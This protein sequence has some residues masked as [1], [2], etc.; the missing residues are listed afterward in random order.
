MDN[1]QKTKKMDEKVY[2]IETEIVLGYADKSRKEQTS[3]VFG[4]FFHH[5][6]RVPCTY[7]DDE[8]KMKLV[9]RIVEEERERGNKADWW[10]SKCPLRK[11]VLTEHLLYYRDHLIYSSEIAV[12]GEDEN[13]VVLAERPK[14]ILAH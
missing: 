8:E 6:Y 1:V 5:V 13:G 10:A 14:Y 11:G 7:A 2:G 4:R 9:E 3:K 12:K